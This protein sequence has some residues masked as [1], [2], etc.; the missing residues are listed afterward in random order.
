MKGNKIK[1]KIVEFFKQTKKVI[2]DNP[3]L[4]VFVVGTLLNDILLRDFT[5]GQ[6]Y[7]I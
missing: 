2:K 3:L 5:I 7:K 6:I 1:K 4:F